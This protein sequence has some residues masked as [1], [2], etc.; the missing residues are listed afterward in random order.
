MGVPVRI[1]RR[2]TFKPFSAWKVKDS[3]IP[4]SGLRMAKQNSIELT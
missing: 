4:H 3:E 1:T 2:L